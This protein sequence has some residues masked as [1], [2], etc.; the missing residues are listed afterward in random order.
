M[1]RETHDHEALRGLIYRYAQCADNRD[2][3][4]FAAQFTSDGLLDGLGF[5]YEGT[6]QIAAVAPQLSLYARTY[7]TVFNCLFTV[8]GDEATGEIYSEAHHLTPT[9][10]GGE[11]SDLVMYITYHDRYRRTVDGWRIAVR[12]VD[13]RMTETRTVSVP[14]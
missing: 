5:R 9:G 3:P 7:H 2:G 11:H 6:E 10:E 8:T 1:E 13:I 14:E 4:G 12:K